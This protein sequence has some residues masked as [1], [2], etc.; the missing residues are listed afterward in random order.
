M[1]QQPRPGRRGRVYNTSPD[2][3]RTGWPVFYPKQLMRSDMEAFTDVPRRDSAEILA[4]FD[5]LKWMRDPRQ[6]IGAYEL[7]EYDVEPT[8]LGEMCAPRDIESKLKSIGGSID[9]RRLD[10]DLW[11]YYRLKTCQQG[12]EPCRWRAIFRI[13]EMQGEQKI[14]IRPGDIVT[15]GWQQRIEVVYVTLR[16]DATYRD[17]RRYFAE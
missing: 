8:H 4:A 10:G 15:V 5:I 7:Y 17:I 3:W 11:G 12:G 2:H 16:Y 1:E 13:V 14:W 6:S 9:I